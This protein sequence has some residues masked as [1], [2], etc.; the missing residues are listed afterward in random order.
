MAI[1]GCF[2]AGKLDWSP[3]HRKGRRRLFFA[4]GVSKKKRHSRFPPCKHPIAKPSY[5]AGEKKRRRRNRTRSSHRLA[6]VAPFWH[7]PERTR[8]NRPA[9]CRSAPGGGYPRAAAQ[10]APRHSAIGFTTTLGRGT[11]QN[12]RL[13]YFGAGG[14]GYLLARSRGLINSPSSSP[15]FTTTH[16]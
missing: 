1:L 9:I 13:L 16:K 15:G 14:G 6:Y 2:R 8:K 12:G 7:A 5:R 3:W 4:A 10:K 11:P